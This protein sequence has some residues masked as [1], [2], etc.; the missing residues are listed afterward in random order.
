MEGDVESLNES[1]LLFAVPI[2]ILPTQ[3]SCGFTFFV[4]QFEIYILTFDLV[5][6]RREPKVTS[7]MGNKND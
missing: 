1:Y 2:P 4:R 7:P 3:G 6:G 5:D